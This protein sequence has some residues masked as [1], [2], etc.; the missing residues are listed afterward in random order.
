MYVFETGDLAKIIL[1]V[2]VMAVYGITT[3]LASIYLFKK[4]DLAY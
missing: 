2:L 1:G 3:Y 4:K